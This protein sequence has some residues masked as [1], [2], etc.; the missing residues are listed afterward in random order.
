MPLKIL[1]NKD[2]FSR[3]IASMTRD[4]RPIIQYFLNGY[5]FFSG[6]E[7]HL[8]GVSIGLDVYHIGLVQGTHLHKS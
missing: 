7:H 2:W 3:K 4:V 1:R 5:D 8:I 6:Y